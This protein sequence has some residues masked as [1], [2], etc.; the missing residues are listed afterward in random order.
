MMKNLKKLSREEMKKILG[1][2]IAPPA[3]GH[4]SCKADADCSKG[5]SCIHVPGGGDAQ[6][7]SAS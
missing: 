4:G 5:C 1:G 6:C 3:C 2:E 7:S